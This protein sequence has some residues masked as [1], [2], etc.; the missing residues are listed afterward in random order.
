MEKLYSSVLR[1]VLDRIRNVQVIELRHLVSQAHV[2]RQMS[3]MDLEITRFPTL[4]VVLDVQVEY[5]LQKADPPCPRNMPPVVGH[6]LWAQQLQRRVHEAKESCL[7][8]R[9]DVHSTP[10]FRK[11]MRVA[12]VTEEALVEYMARWFRAWTETLEVRRHHGM[13]NLNVPADS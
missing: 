9:E 8:M 13:L 4:N 5:D 6:I 3:T 7:S 10:L 1:R 11:V 12:T 2:P